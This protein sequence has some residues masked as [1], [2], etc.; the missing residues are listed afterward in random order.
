MEVNVTF[1]GLLAGDTASHLVLLAVAD[2]GTARGD[3]HPDLHRVF[4]HGVTAGGYDHVF[5]LTSARLQSGNGQATQGDAWQE[6]GDAGEGC[7]PG[8]GRGYLVSTTQVPGGEIRRFL[9]TVAGGAGPGRGDRRR[10]LA[11]AG[12]AWVGGRRPGA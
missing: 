6:T 10:G 12:Y 2:T 7:R 8:G 9:R 3:H 5:D 11:G 1:S 4:E